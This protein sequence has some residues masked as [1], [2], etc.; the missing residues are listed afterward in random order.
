M[1]ASMMN[2]ISMLKKR[3]SALLQK[4]MKAQ[5]NQK[6]K[7]KVMMLN[8]SAN[9]TTHASYRC[10]PSNTVQEARRRKCIKQARRAQSG[11]QEGDGG[12]DSISK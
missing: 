12:L 11:T 8:S 10:S 5:A 7:A 9:Y 3:S 1:K 6:R 4:T 2:S